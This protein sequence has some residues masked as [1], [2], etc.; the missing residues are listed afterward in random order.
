MR[1]GIIQRSHSPTM[2]LPATVIRRFQAVPPNPRETD[3]YGPYNKLPSYL[4]PPDSAF[5]VVPPQDLVDSSRLDFA[6]YHKTSLVFGLEVKTPTD[7]MYISSR[8]LA[9]VHMRELLIDFGEECPIPTLHA[10]SAMGTRLC[11]YQ[12]D[13]TDVAAEIVPHWIPQNSTRVIDTAPAERWDCDI[14]DANGE[15]RLRTVADEIKEACMNIPN[16]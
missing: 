14:L 2:P 16:A 6:V 10:V 15:Q 3:F 7:L 5:T 12:L 11:F 4:F 9:D 1:P 8:K 13:T